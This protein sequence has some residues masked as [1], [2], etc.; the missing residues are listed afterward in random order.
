M[1]IES[2]LTKFT[3][4]MTHQSGLNVV[5]SNDIIAKTDGKTVW[6]PFFSD[7]KLEGL[8]KELA[9]TDINVEHLMFGLTEHEA[10]HCTTT[11]GPEPDRIGIVKKKLDGSIAKMANRMIAKFPK[12]PAVAI[13]RMTRSVLHQVSNYCEDRRIENKWV[14]RFPGSRDYLAQISKFDAYI[15]KKNIWG[16]L[17]GT[18]PSKEEEEMFKP[19][20]QV[21]ET[22]FQKVTS[23]WHEPHYRGLKA[24]DPKVE[25]FATKHFKYEEIIN[26][27]SVEAVIDYAT[28]PV[29]IILEEILNNILPPPTSPETPKEGEGKPGKGGEGDG[30]GKS[31]KGKGTAEEGSGS[32]KKSGKGEKP[33]E[34]EG[35]KAPKSAAGGDGEPEGD[36]EAE[37]EGESGAAD[38]EFEDEEEEEEYEGEDEGEGK[39]DFDPVSYGAPSSRRGEGAEGSPGSCNPD[40]KILKIFVSGADKLEEMMGDPSKAAFKELAKIA[41]KIERDMTYDKNV[42]PIKAWEPLTLEHDEV[43]PVYKGDERNYEAFRKGLEGITMG[44]IGRKLL[45]EYRGRHVAGP[46]GTK[47]NLR[48]VGGLAA[49]VPDLNIM[50]LRKEARK[51]RKNVVVQLVVDCSGSMSGTRIRLA[52]QSAAAMADLLHRLSIPFEVIGFTTAYATREYG[53]AAPVYHEHGWTRIEPLFFPLFKGFNDTHIN[54]MKAMAASVNYYGK[55]NVDGESILFCANRLLARR[56]RRKIQIVL[57]DGYPA[58]SG[59]DSTKANKHLKAVAHKLETMPG[60]ELYGIGIQSTAVKDFYKKWVSLDLLSDLPKVLGNLLSGHIESFTTTHVGDRA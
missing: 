8:N 21:Y 42:D 55:N 32:G 46:E 43:K 1:P 30:K 10:S 16:G 26:L 37:G 31:K 13:N 20:I 3:R 6:I 47:I 25:A 53:S 17:I 49:G 35:E 48:A 18:K 41:K 24:L 54:G 57:S 39:G 44:H 58:F 15:T 12:L 51:S 45:G 40:E 38:G 4:V 59:S 22:L 11:F 56:E 9:K 28:A 27:P 7:A 29:E 2:I 19:L 50:F 14:E 33:E 5:Q 36:E 34:K 60:F 52:M 23:P